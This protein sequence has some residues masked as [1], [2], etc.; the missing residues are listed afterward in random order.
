MINKKPKQTNR[1][2]DGLVKGI[3]QGWGYSLVVALVPSMYE[4]L[5]LI[6]IIERGTKR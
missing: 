6:L 2:G 5:G 4:A 1:I 3:G